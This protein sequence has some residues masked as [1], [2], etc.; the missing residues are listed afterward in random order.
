MKT[1]LQHIEINKESYAQLPLFEFLRDE[2]RTPQERL[3]FLPHIAFFIM[4]FSDLNKFVLRDETP[5]IDSYQRKVNAHTYEDDHHWPWY[6]EDLHKL[7]Y[8]RS[9]TLA[10]HLEGALERRHSGESAIDLSAVRADKQS[11]R[12]GADRG[13]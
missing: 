12:A 8:N 5:S 2:R 7:G 11:Q 10:A 9:A 13:D 4:A 3:A 6:L 1:V